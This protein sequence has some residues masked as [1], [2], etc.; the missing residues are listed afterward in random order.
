MGVIIGAI[1]KLSQHLFLSQVGVLSESLIT[2][3]FY[4]GGRGGG[5]SLLVELL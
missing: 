1:E 5:D 3:L 2:F 4:F